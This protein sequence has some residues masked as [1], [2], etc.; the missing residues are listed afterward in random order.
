MDLS[1]LFSFKVPRLYIYCCFQC[2][3][4]GCDY[5]LLVEQSQ[6]SALRH[7][8]CHHKRVEFTDQHVADVSVIVDFFNYWK[9][10]LACMLINI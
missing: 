3:I 2:S 10:H 5:V 7:D 1:I 4:A 9:S 8:C 6:V